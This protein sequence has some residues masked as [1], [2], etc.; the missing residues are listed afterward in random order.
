MFKHTLLLSAALLSAQT[1]TAQDAMPEDDIIEVTSMR[2]V[3]A[4]NVTSSVTVMDEIDIEIRNSPYVADQLRAVPGVAV[5][6]SGAVGSLTQIRMRGA[7]ANHTL[8][9]LNGAEISDPTTGETNFGL[10]SGLEVSRV[11][12]V[13]GEQSVLHGS[14]AI[15]GVVSLTTGGTGLRAAAEYGSFDT[16]RG[17]IGYGKKLDDGSFNLSASLF[18]TNGVDTAGLDGEKDGSDS[19][20]L[21]G[22]GEFNVTPD[23]AVGGFAS[24]RESQVETDPDTNF[25]GIRDNADRVSNSDQWIVSGHVTGETGRLSHELR[26]SIG[27]VVRENEADGVFKDETTGQRTKISYSPS[28]QLGT[29]EIGLRLSG[30]V[31]LENEDYERVD[32]N[33]LTFSGLIYDANQKQSFETF[34]LAAEARV[35]YNNIVVNG[36]LRKDD[37]DHRFKNATTWRLGGAYNFDFGTKIRAS[38]GTGIKNPTFTEL[39]GFYP[40]V[41]VGNPNLIPEKSESWE[42]GLDHNFD[43][44]SVSMAYFD[45]K[46]ENE[47]RDTGSTALNLTEDSKRS[48]F[49]AS[50][51]WSLSNALSLSAAATKISSDDDQDVKEIRRPEFTASAA[52]NWLSQSKD[53]FRIG[54]AVDYVSSQDDINFGTFQNVTLDS[55]ALVS[56]TAEYPLAPRLSLTLRGENLLDEKVTD[57]FGYNGTGAGVFFGFKIR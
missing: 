5:S 1:A 48:G 50:A 12:V 44:L 13:S 23:W 56:A 54:A 11:E 39:Y 2:A 17:H 4:K 9:L 53:G 49:E 31:D 30:V 33:I 16:K 36:S 47:I 10:L 51:T 25:D 15:G 29:E 45:A 6:R 19:F 27:Q 21:L 38:F 46:L 35:N 14:D 52:V 41:F 3:T 37:N 7:E 8:V 28:M 34:G 22:S 57:V 24:Y 26:A 40:G 20:S 43:N 32:P 55:Y 18:E 42:I